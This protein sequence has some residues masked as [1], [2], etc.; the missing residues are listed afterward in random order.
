[1]KLIISEKSIAGQRIASILAGKNLAATLEGFAQLFEFSKDNEKYILIPLKGHIVDVD[2]PKQYAYWLGTDLKK[3][4]DVEIEYVGQEKQIISLMEKKALLFDEVIIATD[5]D[6]EGESIGL[7]ALNFVTAKNPK[8]K[9]KR[10]NFSA[11]TNQDIDAAFSSLGELNYDFAESANARREI[12]LI[13]GACLTRF[14][15]IVS[16]RLGK[17]F[18]S[19][20]RV[21]SPVLAL[22][23]HREKERLAFKVE[24]YWEVFALFEKDKKQFEAM[25]KKGRFD[26]E[27]EARRIGA[28]QEKKGI[29]VSIERRQRTLKKPVPFNT[30][31]FLRAASAIGVSAGEAMNIAENLY[32]NGFIS[33]PRTDNTVYPA[34][35]N[36]KATLNE[37]LKVSDFV[38]DIGK[39][40]KQKQIVASRGEKETKDHPPIHPVNA[41]LKSQ[42]NERNWKIYELVVRRFFATIAEDAETEN[43]SV[44]ILLGKEPFIARGQLILK[45]G[46]KEFYPYSSLKEV[47]L[48]DLKKGDE[49]D[50]KKLEVLNKETLPPP[51]YSQGALIKLMEDLGLGTKCLSGE[52]S[53]KILNDSHLKIKPIEELFNKAE[54]FENTKECELKTNNHFHCFSLDEENRLQKSKYSIISKR[55]IKSNEKAFEVMFA[56]GSKIIATENHPIYCYN[57]G[58]SYV[59]VQQLKSGMNAVAVHSNLSND[60][61]EAIEFSDLLNKCEKDSNLCAH[62]IGGKLK[63]IRESMKLTQKEFAENIGAHQGNYSGYES[64]YRPIP[65]W[66][67]KNLKIEPSTISGNNLELK[68]CDIFPIKFNSALSRILAK[69]VGD[70]TFEKSKVEKENAYSFRYCNT[71]PD[72]IEQFAQDLKKVFNVE[73]HTLKQL[74]K[75]K[76]IYY[77]FVPAVVGRIISLLFPQVMEKNASKV[78]KELYADFVGALFDDE[79]HASSTET[80]LFISNTNFELLEQLKL[81]LSELGIES[82]LSKNQFKLFVYGKDNLL[83]FLEKVPIQSM[84]K[85]QRLINIL[86]KKYYYDKTHDPSLITEKK[87]L[88]LLSQ[89]ELEVK[90]LCK[91]LKF[92]KSNI[93]K[94]I[95]RLKAKKLIEKKVYGNNKDIPRKI[96][97]KII[98][99]VADTPYALLGEKV[100][101][102]NLVTKK[103]VA[104]NEVANSP[105]FVFDITNNLSLPNFVL[106]N[107]VVVHNSTRHE[108]IK[109]L[110]FRKYITGIKAIE[111]NNVAFAIIDSLEKYSPL[112]VKPEMTAQVEAEMDIIAAGKKTKKE[113]VDYSREILKQILTDLIANKVTVG[114]DIRKALSQD[115][116]MGPCPGCADGQL[117]M[118]ISRNKKRFLGCT[119]YP[120]CTTTFPLPQKGSLAAANKACIECKMPMIKVIGTRFR[121]EMCVNPNCKTKDEWKKKMADKKL[122]EKVSSKNEGKPSEKI[123]DEA[124][125]VAEKENPK[126]AEAKLEKIVKPKKPRTIKPKIAKK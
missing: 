72:L 67:I 82:K 56:D 59:P 58:F 23:V 20:G 70:G 44:E 101:A 40:L 31:E 10:A 32:M 39:I 60:S 80:K 109:K 111:P 43:L 51:R 4:A 71:N 53:V 37:L 50:L 54:D 117:R 8:I 103:I 73:A 84:Q 68:L 95:N 120:K 100:L 64:D 79:E 16:G 97:Y 28:I 63:K 91:E 121:F 119:N 66:M 26:N 36:L 83:A 38:E 15:S 24:K 13:W 107:N 88:A 6:R 94:Y 7:E 55:Q 74:R 98:V 118:L 113:V 3:L 76:T 81:M 25:H 86:S 22:I 89:K 1:M 65:L 69:L 9:I 14:V 45:K 35:L 126:T 34:S 11:I 93:I 49:V 124:K 114:A 104:I 85:K 2:F 87:I 123:A 115:K 18:L 125:A 75:G 21:Q 108:I 5:S 12:D 52:T 99:N 29:V 41:A 112:V 77:V 92:A 102:P 78:P 122:L 105:K 57:N 46:W 48:P 30:T 106:G 110:Y 61:F 47:I 62:N 17:E 96:K 27:E 19:V 33:Y 42:L 116:I 90:E